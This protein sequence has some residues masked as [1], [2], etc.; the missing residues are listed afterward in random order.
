MRT[1]DQ[2][3]DR[4]AAVL[5]APAGDEGDCPE[6]RVGR[7]IAEGDGPDRP[8]GPGGRVGHG[9]GDEAVKITFAPKPDGFSDE[10]SAVVVA[11]VT[12]VWMGPAAAGLNGSPLASMPL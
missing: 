2:G 12:V 9:R 8:Q 11:S 5:K 6:R 4:K 7:E 10:V 3:R 1:D